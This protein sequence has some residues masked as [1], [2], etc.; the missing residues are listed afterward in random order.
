LE[1]I[2][3][4]KDVSQRSATNSVN[5]LALNTIIQNYITDINEARFPSPLYHIHKPTSQHTQLTATWHA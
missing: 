2:F 3:Y 4:S 1:Q 5:V